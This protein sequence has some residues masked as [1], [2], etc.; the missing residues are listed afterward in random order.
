MKKLLVVLAALLAVSA[1]AQ[2]N[3][4]RLPPIVEKALT[5]ART[6]KYSGTRTVTFW[7][8]AERRTHVELVLKDGPRS[9]I[10]FPPGS[11]SHG[12]VILE[13]GSKR[14]QYMPGSEKVVES[15]SRGDDAV[16]R[17]ASMLRN[18][19]RFR[20]ELTHGGK[21][22]GFPTQ[23]ADITD[24]RGNRLQSL[25]IEPR[26]GMVLKR[27]LYDRV[28]AVVG[29]FEFSKVTFNPKIDPMDF[30]ISRNVRQ[31]RL[32]ELLSEL[33]KRHDFEPFSIIEGQGYALQAVRVLNANSR[34]PVLMQSYSGPNGIVT[35]FQV[36]AMVNPSRLTRLGKENFSAYSWKV[37]GKSLV[38]VGGE[39]RSELA[40]LSELVAR[41]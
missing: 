4:Q 39:N 21:V 30:Q 40:R 20:I 18:A 37:G 10:W 33:C 8:G 1:I 19:E 7:E 32:R 22:A 6:L 31:I 35:L 3:G 15:P 25:W 5:A 41:P 23:R 24:R 12:N 2:L 27:E 9:R 16:R 28:G 17:L 36:K 26:S 38:L 11:P 14:I 13:V 29:S 34:F